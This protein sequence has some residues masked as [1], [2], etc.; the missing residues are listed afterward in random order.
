MASPTQ[1]FARP[2]TVPEVSDRR[3]NLTIAA[4]GIGAIASI[5]DSTIVNVGVDHLSRVFDA[6]LTATQWVITGFLLAMTAIVP[7]SGW[8]IDRIGGRATWMC[9]LGVFLGGSVLCGLAWDLPALIGFRVLQGLGAGLIIPALMTLLTQAAGQQRLMTAMGSFS[10]LVQVGPILG[11]LVGGALLQGANWRWLFLV[12]IPFC[13]AGLVL[14]RMVLPPKPPTAHK[15][16]LDGVG[17][18]LLTPALVGVIYAL[19]NISDLGDL[20]TVKVWAPLV[21]G[22]ALLAGFVGWSLRDGASALIDVRLFTDR[23][24]GVT[25]GL[26]VLA[27]FTMFGGMLLFPLYFQQVRGASVVGT[28]LFMVPQGVGAAVLIIF[29]KRLLQR[30]TARTRIVCGFALMALG[31]LPFAFPG[32]RG[33]TW[34]LV[35]ALTVRGLGV[36]AS[37]SAINA[38]AVAGLPKDEIPRGTTAFN[39][40]QRI[41]APF[42]T[43]TVA[44]LLARA[45]ADAPHG[46]AGL[47]GAFASTFWWTLGFTVFP[48]A[49]ALLL[50]RVPATGPVGRA[51]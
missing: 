32:T 9:A 14:A 49:L 50:P 20:G 45:T 48:V 31:T 11:P 34:L 29:G 23:G 37:T 44:V 46:T 47:A 36:G 1:S 40:V 28:G 21:C 39:I 43:T 19:S 22:L 3:L 33:E 8:L 27:G 26:S 12:N 10:L 15:R 41:G 16:P 7:L 42:G 5:L 2:G 35:A 38:S 17:L 30:V 18:A 6:S 24:F 25:S 13:V 4:L 51:A